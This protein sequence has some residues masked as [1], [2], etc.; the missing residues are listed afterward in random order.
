MYD[1]RRIEEKDLHPDVELTRRVAQRLKEESKCLNKKNL[2]EKKVLEVLQRMKQL[3]IDMMKGELCD[4]EEE[5]CAITPNASCRCT[6]HD[7][8]LPRNRCQ[9]GFQ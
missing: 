1:L 4:E 7:I 9:F 2:S 5:L 3:E 6:R 8:N